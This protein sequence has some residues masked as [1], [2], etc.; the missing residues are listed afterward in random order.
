[1]ITKEVISIECP[2]C[3]KKVKIR[4]EQIIKGSLVKC[5][6]GQNLQLQDEG[7]TTKRTVR[8]LN[9]GIKRLQNTLKQLSR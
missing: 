8:K 2:T 1:M 3:S 4:I 7:G 5:K 9:D 6:C